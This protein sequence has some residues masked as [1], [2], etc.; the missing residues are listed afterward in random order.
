MDVIPTIRTGVPPSHYLAY[1]NSPGWRTTRNRALKRVEWRCERCVS[2]RELEVHHKS[3]ERLGAEWDSDLQVLCSSCHEDEHLEQLEQSPDRIYLKL[4]TEAL[5]RHAYSSIG[6]LSEDVKVRCAALK[7]PYDGPK[8]NRALSLLTGS[9]LT[10]KK[11]EVQADS[12]PDSLPF[13]AAEAHEFLCRIGL[14][15]NMARLCKTMPEVGLSPA[16]QLAHEE[17]L[18][19]QVADVDRELYQQR[20]QM[21]RKQSIE[22]RLEAIFSERPA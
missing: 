10:R 17:R 21:A 5:N 15:N 16:G 9:R 3:Y 14:R 1:L 13:T 7:I 2:K 12:R 22:E 4:A 18:R 6:E 8:I 20:R 19:G 11:P